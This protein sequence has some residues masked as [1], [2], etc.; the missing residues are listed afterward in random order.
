MRFT[1]SVQVL[2]ATA[3]LC[4]ATHAIAAERT[5]TVSGHGEVQAER[6]RAV[7]SMGVEARNPSL[8]AARGEVGKVVDALLKLT[9]D[10]K[11]DPKL[12]RTTRLMV[13]PEYNWNTPERERRLIGYWVQRQ[14]EIDLRNLEQLGI[15]MERGVTLGANQVSAPQLDSS[16]RR[17]LERE[18]LNRA[19]IDARANADVAVRAAG[20]KLG[21]VQSIVTTGSTAPPIPQPMLQRAQMAAMSAEQPESYKAGALTF[22]A[23]V[24]VVYALE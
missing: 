21:A 13:Q 22:N 15:I 9:R 12:V 17:E 10:L 2:I 5:V 6:D 8:D 7:L 3:A 1:V 19:M 18:A 11:I 24:Q 14:V 23:S 16:R 4:C 20:A